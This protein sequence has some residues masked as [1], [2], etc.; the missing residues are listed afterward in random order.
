M[1][2]AGDDGRFEEQAVGDELPVRGQ[3]VERLDRLPDP[4]GAGELPSP[5]LERPR[6]ERGVQLADELRRVLFPCL[7]R[8][9]AR[10]RAQLRPAEPGA[11]VGEEPLLIGVQAYE[12]PVT[13][14]VEAHQRSRERRAVAGIRGP[15]EVGAHHL[16][17]RPGRLGGDVG[18][19][20]EGRKAEERGLDG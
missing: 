5:F 16:H 10:I 9:E 11:D 17:R 7:V 6:R 2:R 8:R 3:L 4:F 20:V 15:A 12:P 14:A 1:H 18:G 19:E 13:G